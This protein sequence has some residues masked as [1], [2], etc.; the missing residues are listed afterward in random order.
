LDL[1]RIITLLPSLAGSELKVLLY[2]LHRADGS[3]SVAAGRLSIAAGTGLHHDT[4]TAAADRLAEIGVIR[5]DRR[6]KVRTLYEFI[7][8]DF[9]GQSSSRIFRASSENDLAG[10]SGPV[11]GRSK[12][13]NTELHLQQQ[14]ARATP[15]PMKPPTHERDRRPAYGETPK[16][17]LD[18]FAAA[19]V[20]ASA[21]AALW[22][23]CRAADPNA[24]EAEI[25]AVFEAA[26]P[27]LR[28]RSVQN[29]IGLMLT[30]VPSAFE[31]SGSPEVRRVRRGQVIAAHP[32]P[33][34]ADGPAGLAA[35]ASDPVVDDFFQLLAWARPLGLS[36]RTPEDIAAARCRR[37]AEERRAS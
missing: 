18:R 30:I 8:P 26:A 2:L 5:I 11:S 12:E 27:R 14:S 34:R 31:G 32:A 23:R 25:W 16:G 7:W 9:P 19:G 37:A 1:Q 10:F 36:L 6:A 24:T 21:V 4:I 13:V 20:E 22:R 15:P 3:A 17:L 28:A 29:P 33:E 35:V